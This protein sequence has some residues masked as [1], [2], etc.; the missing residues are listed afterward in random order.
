MGGSG[1][2]GGGCRGS[3][4]SLLKHNWGKSAY[5]GEGGTRQ[6]TLPF[7]R[8]FSVTSDNH[9]I[10]PID[11]VGREFRQGTVGDGLSVLHSVWGLSRKESK[12]GDDSWGRGHRWGQSLSCLVLGRE[13]AESWTFGWP[14]QVAWAYSQPGGLGTNE[15]SGMGAQGFRC[16]CS[17]KRGRGCAGFYDSALGDTCHHASLPY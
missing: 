11:L 8:L 2:S 3:S 14:L 1:I 4:V 7:T 13:N 10:M 16:G 6:P 15:T 17:S 5:V 9:L 12:P